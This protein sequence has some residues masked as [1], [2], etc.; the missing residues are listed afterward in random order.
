MLIY[1]R[2]I[3]EKISW[4]LTV[5]K[6]ST[7]WIKE[8]LDNIVS[9]YMR[10]W[11]EIPVNGTLKIITLSKS[12]YGLNFI[13]IS[14]RFTQCQAT[15]TNALNNSSNKNIN[16]L[17]QVI[18]KGTNIQADSYLLTRDA[19]KK[20]RSR[21]ETQDPA[22]AGLL[23]AFYSR[24]EIYASLIRVPLVGMMLGLRF[25]RMSWNACI[26]RSYIPPSRV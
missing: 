9:N 10:P 23:L 1:Q 8:N 20:I 26:S 21:T 16:K 11:L 25:D 3:L 13:N 2:Y 6:I 7:T 22:Y 19:I 5:S 4:H 15:F 14:T 24:V 18:K 12:K 17:H